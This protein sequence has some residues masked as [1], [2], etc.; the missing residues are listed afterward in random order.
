M[1]KY[2]AMAV[3][4]IILTII[5]QVAEGQMWK[6]PQHEI[7]YANNSDLIIKPYPTICIHES[8]VFNNGWNDEVL[9]GWTTNVINEWVVGLKN[10]S[11]NYEVWDVQ[12][13]MIP[14]ST[15]YGK[16]TQMFPDCDVNIVFAGTP[17][18]NIDTGESIQGKVNRYSGSRTFV[19]LKL[20]TW[21]YTMGEPLKELEEQ[22][23]RDY[24]EGNYTA[25]YSVAPINETH[26]KNTMKHEI[27]HAF[28]LGHHKWWGKYFWHEEKNIKFDELHAEQSLMYGMMANNNIIRQITDIDYQAIIEKFEVDGWG[29]KTNW[30]P[31]SFVITI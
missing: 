25:H 22:I 31:R 26:F 4:I 10:Y 19:D 24:P 17:P 1:K 14:N 18:L 5:L 23:K 8:K 9:L 6:V 16:I 11:G 29:G 3:G 13:Q 27:G 12:I 15:A 21:T 2:L 28:G 20:Y 7:Y 30:N